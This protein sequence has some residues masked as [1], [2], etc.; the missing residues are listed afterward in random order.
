MSISAVSTETATVVNE[1]ANDYGPQP[2]A[3]LEVYCYL[4]FW[5]T[6]NAY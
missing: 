2:I 5:R 1:E 3:K 4:L 6:I